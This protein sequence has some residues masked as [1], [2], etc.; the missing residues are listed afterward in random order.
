M[1][2]LVPELEV[3][4]NFMDANGAM[5]VLRLVV[6]LEPVG[7]RPELAGALGDAGIVAYRRGAILVTEH[8]SIQRSSQNKAW[9]SFPSCMVV[10]ARKKARSSALN[11]R[12]RPPQA[13]ALSVR[14]NQSQRM[15]SARPVRSRSW[16]PRPPS[17]I[18]LETRLLTWQFP[19]LA[20]AR[21]AQRNPLWTFSSALM[22]FL[23]GASTSS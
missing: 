7:D 17:E 2:D 19:P 21:P 8:P 22:V 23:G 1:L 18:G 4:A 3:L 15:R 5:D 6:S 12:L 11:C 14:L 9:C 20:S 10:E 16:T 13:L